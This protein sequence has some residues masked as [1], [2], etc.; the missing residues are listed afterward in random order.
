MTEE[1][2]LR[3]YG[4]SGIWASY[5]YPYSNSVT[6]VVSGN[7][8]AYPPEWESVKGCLGHREIKE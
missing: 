8:L 6:K 2:N 7:K 1:S 5:G 4:F 3:N